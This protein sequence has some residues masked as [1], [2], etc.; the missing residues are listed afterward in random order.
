MTRLLILSLL[1]C[2]C[3]TTTVTSPDGTVTKTESVDSAT[4]ATVAATVKDI[5]AAKRVKAQ[6]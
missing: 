1:L 3:T 4:V 6:K 5:A 2:G